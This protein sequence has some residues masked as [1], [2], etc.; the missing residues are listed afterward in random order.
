M[1][2]PLARFSTRN[3]GR[4]VPH[5][6]RSEGTIA[7][8]LFTGV[9]G[10]LL[11][12]LGVLFLFQAFANPL[13]H[14]PGGCDVEFWIASGLVQVDFGVPL[15]ILA[16]ALWFRTRYHVMT[17]AAVKVVSTLGLVLTATDP[18]LVPPIGFITGVLGGLAAL[19][20][21]CGNSGSRPIPHPS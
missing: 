12:G 14:G 5:S 10:S 9:A 11:T 16:V 2:A 13:C 8:S 4:P 17:G 1:A 7:A 3:Y 15:L 20:W 19:F 6:R 18:S 21:A